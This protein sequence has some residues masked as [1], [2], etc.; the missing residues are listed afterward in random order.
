VAV[1]ERS[2]RRPSRPGRGERAEQSFPAALRWLADA[3]PD[4][5]A[6]VHE[7]RTISRRDLDRASNRMA[8]AY[9]ALG[10]G[11][12]RLVTITLPNGIDWYVAAFATWKLGAVPNPVS[13]GLPPRE[14]AA[15]VDLADPALVVGVEAGAYGDRPTVPAGFTPDPGLDD[16]PLPDATS[17]SW[18]AMT[19]GGSTGRP[20]IVVD[21]LPAVID[22]RAPS[23][24]IGMQ[25][26]GVQLVPGPLYHN[27]PFGFSVRGLLTGSTLVV[28]TRFDAAEALRLLEEHRVDWVSFVPT[29]STRILKLD[30]AVRA[31]ADL[32][33]LRVLFSTGSAWPAWSKRAWID[34]LGPDRVLEAYGGTETQTGTLI[35]GREWL[36]RPGSVGRPTVGPMRVLDPITFAELAPGEIGEL[37]LMP[38]GGPGTTYRY[39]GATARSTPDGWE[40]LGDMGWMD[41]DGYVYLADR[42]TDMIVTGGANV[43]PAEVEAALEAH[44]GV[45]SS[46][47]IGL[48]D[49]DLGQRVHAIVDAP[50]TVTEADLRAH[51][52]ERLVRYKIPRTFEWVDGLLRD[53]A[54]KVRRSALRAERQAGPA[55]GGADAATGP[56]G[57]PP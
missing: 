38:A 39:I 45:R 51:L 55:G 23:T 17:P 50:A 19:S 27:G 2:E 13:A 47:V 43:Y 28:M 26:D 12:G 37:F 36:E 48:S 44:P 6:V 52:A 41:A 24:R 42:R 9:G 14:R 29:M 33:S 4:R 10:V 56:P 40:S 31:A 18:K 16:G 1:S 20:K 7:G 5:P 11:P 8:R 54:G 34:W 53:D 49:D 25:V 57:D 46:C 21:A 32:S 3:N 30:P 35:T 15:I 22:P